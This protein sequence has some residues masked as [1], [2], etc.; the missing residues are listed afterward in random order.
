MIQKHL[1]GIM[2]AIVLKV[3]N[4]PAESINSRIKIVQTH[5]CGFR[6]NERFVN[7]VY[8]HLGGFDLST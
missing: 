5:A 2:N 7:A 8:F 6:N 3:S 1:W 4:G